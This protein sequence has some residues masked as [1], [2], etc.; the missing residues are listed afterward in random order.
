[1]EE[2]H[3]R[4]T[5]RVPERVRWAVGLLDVGPSDHL[6]EIGCGPGHAIALICPQL[7]DGSITAIDR[8]PTMIERARARNA[9]CLAAGRAHIEQQDLMEAALERRF[10]KVFAVNVNA[11]WTAPAPSIG[12]LEQLL[13]RDGKAF[14]VYEPPTVPRLR[15]LERSLPPQ[16]ELRGFS[17]ADVRAERF[18]SSHGLCIVAVPRAEGPVPR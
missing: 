14:L 13:E 9:A 7:S 17:V 4:V 11:F 2:H 12:A 15:E 16:L 1:M 18:R 8:S 5:R 6:L 3:E 10:T